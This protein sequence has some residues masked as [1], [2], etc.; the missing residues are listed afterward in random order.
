[1]FANN[2]MESVWNDAGCCSREGKNIT[3]FEMTDGATST[4]Q[5]DIM[6]HLSPS[7]H[8]FLPHFIYKAKKKLL[9]C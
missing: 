2:G 7:R 1:M 6:P 9:I 8:P 3:S 5:V 4:N